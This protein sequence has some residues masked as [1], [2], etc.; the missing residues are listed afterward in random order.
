MRFYAVSFS[1]SAF[2]SMAER[3]VAAP[4]RTMNRKYFPRCAAA[5][6]TL[7]MFRV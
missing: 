7:A 6:T 1:T 4:A 5:R 3:I 2:P